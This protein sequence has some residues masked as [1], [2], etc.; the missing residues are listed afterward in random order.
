MKTVLA[1]DPALRNLAICRVIFDDEKNIIDVEPK[2]VNVQKKKTATFESINH[3]IINELNSLSIDDVDLV[4][5]EN[6][7]S[8]LNPRVKSV[9]V[10]IFTYFA[11]KNKVVHFVSASLKLASE[12]YADKSNYNVRKKLSIIKSKSL[13][14]ETVNEKVD[15]YVTSNKLPRADIAD[16]ICMAHAYIVR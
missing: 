6:Q 9:A 11:I 10:A 13:L 2:L 14:T 8:M 4:L 3:N 1:I 5:I 7:P 15:D 12:K 16:C